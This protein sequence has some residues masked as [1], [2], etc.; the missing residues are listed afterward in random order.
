MRVR[1]LKVESKDIKTKAGQAMT[2]RIAQG[3]TPEGDVFKFTLPRSHP[4]IK[5]GDHD[6]V[7]SVRVGFDADLQGQIVLSPAGAK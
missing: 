3:M 2:L 4:D 6:A 5:T 1:I 7:A